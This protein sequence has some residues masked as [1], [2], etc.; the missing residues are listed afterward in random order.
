LLPPAIAARHVGARLPAGLAA[1][2][3]RLDWPQQ[4]GTGLPATVNHG[5]ILRW[6]AALAEMRAFA[7]TPSG[8]CRHVITRFCARIGEAIAAHP[9]LVLHD[10]PPP[11]R[12]HDDWDA[13]QTI[14]SFSVRAPDGSLLGLEALRRLH[15]ALNL[16][17]SPL[18]GAPDDALAAR[19][20]HIGQPV[21][22][23]GRHAAIRLAAG[24]RLVS[25]VHSD[26]ALGAS[27][28]LRLENEI[29][30]ACLALDKISL[31]LRH[32]ER[33]AGAEI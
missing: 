33:L 24:A 8:L 12:A 13:A 3:S 32:R 5:L 16:D 9:N 28:E 11:A 31:I 27:F 6:T 10:A 22:L 2:V 23:G 29:A 7:A 21:A 1:Y 19:C 18:I 25:G 20:C 17:L 30:D 15:R 14:F 26:P 4:P